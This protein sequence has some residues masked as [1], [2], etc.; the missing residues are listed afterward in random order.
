MPKASVVIPTYNRAP[1]VKQAVNSVLQQSFTDFESIIVDDGSTDD[2]RELIQGIKDPRVKYFYKQNGGVASARNFGYAKASGQFI[3]NLDSDDL[4][5]N[6]F[7]EVMVSKLEENTDYGAAYACRTILYRDGTTKPDR[8]TE[9]PK[10]GWVTEELFLNKSL[11]P[12]HTSGTCFRVNAL[13]GF[14]YEESLQNAADYD[15][16]LR[17]ST[18]VK[19]LF[20][21]ECSFL[22]RKDHDVN[23]RKAFSR[24]NA[25]RIRIL[26][27][28]YFRLGGC[29]FIPER[30]AMH[31]ISHAYR[32][33]AKR[34]YEMKHRKASVYL[35]KQALRY[36]PYDIR[37][38]LDLAK[39]VSIG[40][41][42]DSLPD[43]RMPDPLP[44]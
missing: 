37:L 3:C 19:F 28:F 22:Y 23:P 34:H 42:D 2:T 4:W 6:N 11:V 13:E 10:S 12:I 17:I 29:D 33:V 36:C 32:S 14:R 35:Y 20:M 9:H 41:A 24:V 39:S 8:S 16:W 44:A 21:P 25:N 18:K 5:K 31:R 27:R 15:Y 30:Q 43:W 40:K 7:L 1:L 38:F 26:E